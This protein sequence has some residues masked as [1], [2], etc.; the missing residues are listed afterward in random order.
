MDSVGRL[1]PN[2]SPPHFCLWPVRAMYI[3]SVCNSFPSVLLFKMVSMISF[4]P[5]FSVDLQSRIKANFHG[6]FKMVFWSPP[7]ITGM[8]GT[9]VQT[10]FFLLAQLRCELL[11]HTS[12]ILPSEFPALSSAGYSHPS[13]L[14]W[15]LR[16]TWHLSELKWTCCNFSLKE[17][18]FKKKILAASKVLV[19]QHI[20]KY[21]EF[22]FSR[23]K[24]NEKLKHLSC[25]LIIYLMS[26][27]CTA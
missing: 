8:F 14:L 16:R 6:W 1:L 18:L 27:I 17:I 3:D 11:V 9:Q 24:N 20:H 15:N 25:T 21:P 19:N 4:R 22:N 26:G 13:S 10:P 2:L 7:S 5:S 23:G 12:H